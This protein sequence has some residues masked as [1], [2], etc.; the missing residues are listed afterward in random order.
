[1][2]QARSVCGNRQRERILEIAKNNESAI[3]TVVLSDAITEG[4]GEGKEWDINGEK[5]VISVEVV[6]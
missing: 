2:W 4:N 1:M 6:K 3:S 5:A